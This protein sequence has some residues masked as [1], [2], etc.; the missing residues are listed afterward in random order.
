MKHSDIQAGSIHTPF[1]WTYADATARLAASGF[2]SGDVGKVALQESDDTLWL[3]SSSSPTWDQLAGKPAINLTGAWSSTTAYNIGD[4]A[5]S[6]DSLWLAIQSNTN[7]TPAEDTYWTLFL[8]D[9]SAG[10]TGPTGATGA[11]GP[12]G[13]TGATGATGPSGANQLVT[14]AGP[15]SNVSSLSG[16]QGAASDGDMILLHAQTTTH[17]NGPWVEHSGSW[18]RPSWYTSG[19]AVPAGFTMQI[20]SGGYQYSTWFTPTAIATVDT[21]AAFYFSPVRLSVADGSATVQEVNAITFSGATV[22]LSS[23]GE[24]LVTITGGGTGI[25]RSVASVSAATTA[26]AT[27]DT[28]Y[29]Y[30]VSGTT[31]ITL[32]TAV[33]NTNRYT[34]K[35]TGSAVVTIATTSAQ[36]IDGAS[37]QTLAVS[38]SLDLVSDGANWNI[39]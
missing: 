5:R 26:G 36:T 19:S 38:E 1:N 20:V 23:P 18:V 16:L 37:T 30:F 22:S 9:G 29:V 17:E 33:S 11:T 8:A 27:A 13:A 31:T 34:V 32:P 12:T 4:V 10:S 21:S 2:A 35:N 39:V 3:L 25:V 24:A 14:W 15:F 6:G 7:Q 28:D